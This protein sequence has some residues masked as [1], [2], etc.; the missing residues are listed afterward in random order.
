VSAPYRQDAAGVR[1]MAE[2]RRAAGVE[3]DELDRAALADVGEIL[4]RRHGDAV[5]DATPPELVAERVEALRLGLI[6]RRSASR[7]ARNAGAGAIAPDQASRGSQGRL[8]D[9]TER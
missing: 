1:R 3:L 7:V 4:D 9:G 6:P 5:D 8:S 2:A